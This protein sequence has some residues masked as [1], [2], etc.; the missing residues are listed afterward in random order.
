MSA[1]PVFVTGGTGF[2]GGRLVAALLT[3][4]RVVRALARPASRRQAGI[5]EGVEWVPGDVLDPDSVRRGMAGCTEVFH[6]AACARSWAKYPST[7][8]RF[9]V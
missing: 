7:F 1:A 3:R 9:N 4:G 6:L 2:V 8:F 5:A